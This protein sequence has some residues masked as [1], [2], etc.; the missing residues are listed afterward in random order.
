MEN[1]EF[2]GNGEARPL[3]EKA[4]PG[5]KPKD[6]SPKLV[7]VKL[8][9]NYRPVNPFKVMD[10]EFPDDPLSRM[11]ERDPLG[12]PDVFKEDA[13]SGLP[14]IVNHATGEFAKVN[15][16]AFED[17]DPE[18]AKSGK[19]LPKIKVNREVKLEIDEARRCLARR[20]AERAD[21]L[22]AD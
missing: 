20:I 21:E 6:D 18:Q 3:V 12:N 10:R 7:R 5:R 15:A 11:I 16:I 1:V 17:D 9:R 4:K 22:T 19:R 13:E 8:L 14:K 2:A